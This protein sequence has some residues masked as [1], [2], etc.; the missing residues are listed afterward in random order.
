MS[1]VPAEQTLESG[2]SQ[3]PVDS[4][5]ASGDSLA[6]ESSGAG[7][8]TTQSSSTSQQQSGHHL[9]EA[10]VAEPEPMDISAASGPSVI[11]DSGSSSSG[12]PVT[13]PSSG[14]D[15]D[16]NVSAENRE[17]L[18]AI[19]TISAKEVSVIRT[20]GSVDRSPMIGERS[21]VDLS[22]GNASGESLP[23]TS[24]GQDRSE[25][26]AAASLEGASLAE[27]AVDTLPIPL[28]SRQSEQSANSQAR[29]TDGNA[30]ATTDSAARSSGDKP[31]Q[32]GEGGKRRPSVSKNAATRR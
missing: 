1:T 28:V 4:Q 30:A 10:P 9:R 5:L 29:E 6:P 3:A 21:G 19:A 23:G 7:T 17:L 12:A 14:G 2:S 16:S 27:S 22:Q 11:Q 15:A 13:N 20:T 25:P 24:G 8:S 18:T 26:G 32:S 31:G